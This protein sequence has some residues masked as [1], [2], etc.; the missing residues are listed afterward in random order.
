MLLNVTFMLNL[1]C[2]E[3]FNNV[4]KVNIYTPIFKLFLQIYAFL[5][6]KLTRTQEYEAI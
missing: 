3:K 5:H 1:S 6:N 4:I 2:P